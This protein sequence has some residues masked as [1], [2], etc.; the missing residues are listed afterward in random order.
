MTDTQPHFSLDRPQNSQDHSQNK[1][2]L[3]AHDAMLSGEVRTITSDNAS[4]L[5]SDNPKVVCLQWFAFA[6]VVCV[7]IVLD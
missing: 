1:Q 2:F 7:G 4:L 5:V 3:T 6:A